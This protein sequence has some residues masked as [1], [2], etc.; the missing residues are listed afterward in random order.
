MTISGALGARI[1]TVS[2][3][4]DSIHL[5]LEPRQKLLILGYTRL[6]LV[7]QRIT[8]DIGHCVVEGGDGE[9]IMYSRQ[10]SFL[11]EQSE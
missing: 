4:K 8:G 11:R 3:Y 10:G 5:M 6:P 7:G 1:V 2:V 9:R